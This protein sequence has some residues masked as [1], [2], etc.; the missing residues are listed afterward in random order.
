[1]N[2]KTLHTPEGHVQRRPWFPEKLWSLIS[3]VI[4]S[5]YPYPKPDILPYWPST[6]YSKN[7]EQPQR[8]HLSNHDRLA[9]IEKYLDSKKIFAEFAPR[10]YGFCWFLS[11]FFKVVYSINALSSSHSSA[12]S[13][14]NFRQISQDGFKLNCPGNSVDIVY[15]NEPLAY[16]TKDDTY[17]HFH[18]IQHLLCPGGVY[19]FRFFSQYRSSTLL[20][21]QSNISTNFKLSFIELFLL[22]R[23]SR[24]SSFRCYLTLGTI[25]LKIPTIYC[26]WAERIIEKLPNRFFRSVFARLFMPNPVLELFK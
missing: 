19:I 16:I 11:P 23:E 22:I 2:T 6:T 15:R 21:D 13:P 4:S 1:M 8:L 14:Y 7:N 10:D 9:L 25:H 24:F 26:I 12:Y 5:I 18:N 3:A 20:L 17:L